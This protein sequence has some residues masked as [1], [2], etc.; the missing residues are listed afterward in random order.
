VIEQVMMRALKSRGGLTT[1][2][3]MTE[4]VRFLWVRSMHMCAAWYACLMRLADCDRNA[5]EL[6][7]VEVSKARAARDYRDSMKMLEWFVS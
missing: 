6:Q 1:G 3:G 5:D 7:H 4:S 2:R